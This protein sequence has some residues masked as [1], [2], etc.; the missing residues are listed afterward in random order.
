MM[1]ASV[2][3]TLKRGL[4][5]PLVWG[6]QVAPP[7]LVCT[8]GPRKPT[9]ERFGSADK[10]PGSPHRDAPTRTAHVVNRLF[11][12]IMINSCLEEKDRQGLR[13]LTA[14]SL[15]MAA[16]PL[17]DLKIFKERLQDIRRV[18]NPTKVREAP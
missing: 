9:A 15:L 7:S 18:H 6:A 14:S 16:C 4:L 17:K 5:V 13:I 1:L 11:G 3:S 12:E 8:I 2:N 10:R